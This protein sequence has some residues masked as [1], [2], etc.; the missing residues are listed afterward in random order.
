MKNYQNLNIGLGAIISPIRGQETFDPEHCGIIYEIKKYR[1]KLLYLVYWTDGIKNQYY[2]K[3][4]VNVTV[5][6]E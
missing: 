4:I 2:K 5:L 3:Q 6:F 1:G